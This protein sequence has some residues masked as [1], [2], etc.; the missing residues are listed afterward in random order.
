[1]PTQSEN[2]IME[3]C[4]SHVWKEKNNYPSVSIARNVPVVS[5]F[6]QRKNCIISKMSTSSRYTQHSQSTHALS[7]SKT[8]SQTYVKNQIKG[9]TCKHLA[10][11]LRTST[12]RTATNIP[13]GWNERNL[14][15]TSCVF[16]L[17]LSATDEEERLIPIY[18]IQD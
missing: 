9:H 16:L 11:R 15:L 8:Q 6:Y 1:M 5:F 7:N 12:Q 10:S 14:L 17:P 13:V 4:A 18:T 2:D 3:I